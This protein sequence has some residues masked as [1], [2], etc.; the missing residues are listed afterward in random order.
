MASKTRVVA[1]QHWAGKAPSLSNGNVLKRA[2]G[3]ARRRDRSSLSS[4]KRMRPWF[5]SIDGDIFSIP[6]E[7]IPLNDASLKARFV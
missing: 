4:L 2:L 5:Y 6:V 3:A 1:T 7:D